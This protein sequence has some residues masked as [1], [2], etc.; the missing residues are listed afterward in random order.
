MF[1]PIYF[2][3]LDMWDE[4]NN[5]STPIMLGRPFMI[6]SYIKIDIQNEKLTMEFNWDSIIF[7]IFEV[8]RYLNDVKS[9]YHINVLE[10][11]IE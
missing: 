2:Y 5:I 4:A 10:S 6:I 3:E 8:I 1:F 9:C 11:C 7:N